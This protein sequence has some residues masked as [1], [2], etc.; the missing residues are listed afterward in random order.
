[1][2]LSGVLSYKTPSFLA[3][4][5]TVFVVVYL[6]SVFFSNSWIIYTSGML[7]MLAVAL[8]FARASS[9]F[10][11]TGLIFIIV[12]MSLMI[13]KEISLVNIPV[14]F[15][16]MAIMIALF[17]ALP[18]MNSIITVGKY[19]RNVNKLLKKDIHNL[20]QMYQR[21]SLTSYII[22]MFLNIG[23][24]SFVHQVL[25]R[26]LKNSESNMKNRYIASLILRGY[27]LCL[28]WS[29]MEILVGVT[30]DLTEVSYFTILPYL[31]TLS[32]IVLMAD[33]L[34]AKRYKQYTVEHAIHSVSYHE[35]G[36]VKNIFYLFVHLF[37]FIAVVS[38]FKYYFQFSFLTTVTLAILP[39]SIFWAATINKLKFYLKYS[40]MVWERKTSSLQNYVVLFLG[41]GFFISVLEETNL[42][43]YLQNP[44]VQLA[45]SPF[46]LFAVI[47]ILFICLAMV[48]FHPLVTMAVVGEAIKPVLE[49][50]NPVAISIVLI[51]SGLST[52]MSGPYN[53]SVSLMSMLIH[54]NPYKV[55]LYNLRF[56]LLFSSAGTFLALLLV[57]I[58]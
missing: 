53:V 13:V 24:I 44:V 46:V 22:G 37:L 6:L 14:Y 42:M 12:G 18:F 9:L 38:V 32:V 50:I 10:K 8:S 40:A 28:V 36:I 39:Y 2:R 11:R 19:D 49:T 29:P 1:M 55:S 48:G 34:F 15:N 45:K 43:K 21:G 47:Q 57:H 3:V 5:Y 31:F 20:G 54:D 58:L 16:R 23:V 4:F 52:V 25:E 51:T 35:A 56:A 26:S 27:A 30:I 33:W 17:V 41:L 7:G